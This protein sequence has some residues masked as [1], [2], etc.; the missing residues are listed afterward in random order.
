MIGKAGGGRGGEMSV[1]VSSHAD[2]EQEA[3]VFVSDDQQ[4]IGMCKRRRFRQIER[5]KQREQS[6]QLARAS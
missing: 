6:E 5:A 4:V 1:A 2:P 3:R